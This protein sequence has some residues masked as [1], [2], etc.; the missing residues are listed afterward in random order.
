[1]TRRDFWRLLLRLQVEGLTVLLTTP[2][3]DEAE[4]CQRVGLVERGRLLALDAPERLRAAYPGLVVEILARPAA[5]AIPLLRARPEVA[6]VETF[7]ER[8]HATLAR[9]GPAEGEAAARRLA[10]EL[11]GAGIEV[12]HAA[13][14][15]ALPRGRLHRADPGGRG[16][17]EEAGA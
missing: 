3:L 14:G 1:V 10:E 9:A 11:T 17:A 7:G 6:E 15:G 4:R 12:E 5:R 13:G 2:Y 16:R 8:L